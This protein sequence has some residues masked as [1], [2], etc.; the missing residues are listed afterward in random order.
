MRFDINI[1]FYNSEVTSLL[2]EILRK[3]NTMSAEFDDLIA[4]VDAIE[5]VAD[6]CITVLND[7]VA[8]LIAMQDA[9][10]PE[11]VRAL[12]DRLAAQTQEIADAVSNVPPA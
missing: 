3:V 4:K 9:P 6:G 2:R 11:Q 1:H 10:T 5:T 7:V 8:R 12:A